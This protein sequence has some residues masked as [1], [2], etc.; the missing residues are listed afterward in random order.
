MK[1][2]LLFFVLMLAFFSSAVVHGQT[3]DCE[4]LQAKIQELQNQIS[5]TPIIE[6]ENYLTTVYINN[7]YFIRFIPSASKISISNLMYQFNSENAKAD[8]IPSPYTFLFMDIYIK[9]MSPF[10]IKFNDK[11]FIR[12]YQNEN[13]LQV[14]NPRQTVYKT[15]TKNGQ[16]FVTISFILNNDTDDVTLEFC[17]ILPNEM[18]NHVATW[19]IPLADAV[20]E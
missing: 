20:R 17:E 8:W 5:Q 16:D 3:C 11:V 6:P 10:D 19:I 12:A 13:R 1:K 15:I 2:I 18:I 4:E 7:D 9:N 14:D